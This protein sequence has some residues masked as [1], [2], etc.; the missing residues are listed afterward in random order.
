MIFFRLLRRNVS[1]L[2]VSFNRRRVPIGGIAVSAA[3]GGEKGH[4]LTRMNEKMA[5]F[6]WKDFFFAVAPDTRLVDRALPA[7][8]QTPRR[9]LYPVRVATEVEFVQ[10]PYSHFD[11]DAAAKFTGAAAIRSESMALVE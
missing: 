2:H 4:G 6:S 8:E 3:A 5:K 7:A 9:A 1:Q 10:R 11:A